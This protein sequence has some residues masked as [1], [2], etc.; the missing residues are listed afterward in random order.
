MSAQLEQRLRDHYSNIADELKL[1]PGRLDDILD[2]P[3]QLSSTDETP[4]GA[5][6]GRRTSRLIVVAA[7]IVMVV[8]GLGVIASQTIDDVGSVDDNDEQ[9]TLLSSVETIAAEDWVI[10]TR[11][12]EGVVYMYASRGDRSPPRIDRTVRYG[13]ERLSGTFERMSIAVSAG[14]SI[15]GEPV[16]IEGTQWNVDDPLT[17]GWT[18]V[19]RVGASA[20]AVRD[21]GPFDDEDRD[22]LAG[23]SIAPLDR[24]P[25]R[26][27]GDES[28]AVE[29]ARSSLGAT[30]VVQ[31]SGGY[32]WTMLNGSG[33]CCSRIDTA[34]DGVTV[35]AGYSEVAESTSTSRVA[36]AGTVVTS[37]ELVQVE[38]SDGTIVDSRPTDLSGRFDRKFWVVETVVPANDRTPVE[39][40]SYDAT[41]QILATVT[42]SP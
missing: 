33:G 12:P 16:M 10:A 21:S 20:V 34:A 23:L 38:F 1:P 36:I 29:V 42:P 9:L 39:V 6:L 2:P 14:E 18:A 41:A 17:G 35:D 19:R 32:W 7:A 11:L 26:P 40:R 13:N 4:V 3:V 22:L 30:F 28:E 31:E 24:L 37:A 25:S 15:D 27:L 8:G 5:T